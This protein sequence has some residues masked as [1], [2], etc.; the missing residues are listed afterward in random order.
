MQTKTIFTF[1]SAA[2]LG[3]ILTGCGGAEGGGST[4]D[5]ALN[6][7]SSGASNSSSTSSAVNSDTLQSIE[8]KDATPAVINLKGTGGAEASLVRFRTLGQTGQPIKGIKV[9]FTLT[10]TVGGLQLSQAS[11]TSDKDGYVSTSVIAGTI[12]TS[13]RVAATVLDT[14]EIATQSNQLVIATGRP[15]QKSM[16]LSLEKFNPAAWG[17]DGVKS[18]VSILLADAYNNPAADGTAVYFTT[19]G[20]SIEPSCLTKNGGCSVNWTSQSPM[21]A[22]ST[23]DNSLNRILCLNLVGNDL[24]VCE[25]ERGGRS[26]ILA[27]AIGNESFKDTNGNGVY[28]PAVDIF[29]HVGDDTQEGDAE[30]VAKAKADKCKD[31]VPNSS[32]ESLVLQCDDLAEAYLDTNEN[33]TYEK[34][35]YFVNFITDT[36]N[37]TTDE[38]DPAYGTNYT[39]NNGIYNGD[40]CQEKDEADKK[41][42][43]APVT[44][45]KEH[46]II[47]SCDSPLLDITGNLPKLGTD[48]N[49]GINVYAVADCNGNSLPV[50]TT[51]TVGS[52][53]AITIANQYN[54]TTIYA[55]TGTTVKLSIALDSGTKAVSIITN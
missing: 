11:G 35:E 8:F 42:S 26:T 1:I 38:N 3:L 34:G 45:R 47:M 55:A 37:D 31:N 33:G 7:V 53:P 44:I 10:S 28:D 43:R 4:L 21:P 13:V 23:V 30:D 20:G 19:E 52:N 46:L 48:T 50:G 25:A 29:A 17:Y 5:N 41:C 22:R 51:I 15:D 27:T 24:R 39:S 36:A 12:S 54:W 2:L 9:G 18:K 49:T 40:F 16:S 14:P 6:G 32:F